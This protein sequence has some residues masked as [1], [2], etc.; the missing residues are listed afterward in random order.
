MSVFPPQLQSWV[1]DWGMTLAMQVQSDSPFPAGLF[2]PEQEG[3]NERGTLYVWIDCVQFAP[4]KYVYVNLLVW[5]DIA[6]DE[7]FC[8]NIQ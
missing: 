4:S 6:P 1:E 8:K 2:V 3:Q 7:F 5:D